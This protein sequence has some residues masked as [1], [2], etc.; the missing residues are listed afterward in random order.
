MLPNGLFGHLYSPIKGCHNNAFTLA[1]SGLMDECT[2]HAKLPNTLEGADGTDTSGESCYLQLF[3]DPAYGLNQQIISPFPKQGLTS[4]QQEWNM[5]MSKVR[6]EVEHGFALVINN[7]RFLEAE[8]KHHV[9]QSPVGRYYCVGVL[10]TNAL[11][12]F[13][14]NQVSQYFSCP[15][16]SLEDYFHN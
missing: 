5:Q 11:A 15:P 1:E 9:F 3:G 7:W 4:D 6:I 13:Q 2:L 8:W 10:L 16:P 14:S 12:C